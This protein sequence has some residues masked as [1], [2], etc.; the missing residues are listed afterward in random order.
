[1]PRYMRLQI[2]RKGKKDAWKI[3][4]LLQIIK[5]ELEAREISEKTKSS[6]KSGLFMN[7]DKR[8]G[9]KQSQFPTA[10]KLA[11]GIKR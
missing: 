8:D 11:R 3:D 6:E 7:S 5:F 4:D 9:T 2:A 10:R 1:M